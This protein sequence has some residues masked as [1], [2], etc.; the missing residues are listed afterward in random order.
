MYLPYNT[1][2]LRLLFSFTPCKKDASR[3]LQ[4]NCLMKARIE[5]EQVR[6][7]WHSFI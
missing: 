6:Y 1:G 5:I 3:F 2:R 7:G 4:D